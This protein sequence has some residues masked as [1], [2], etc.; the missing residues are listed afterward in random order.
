MGVFQMLQLWFKGLKP[1]PYKATVSHPNLSGSIGLRM[2]TDDGRSI[3]N[4]VDGRDVQS[5][6]RMHEG[7]PRV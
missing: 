2:E 7:I 5:V 3:G 4:L 1:L 6:D